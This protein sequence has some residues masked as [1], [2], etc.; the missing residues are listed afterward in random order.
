M[1]DCAWDNGFYLHTFIIAGLP[2]RWSQYKVT[3]A[4]TNTICS[5]ICWHQISWKNRFLAL[6]YVNFNLRLFGEVPIHAPF[7]GFSEICP[8]VESNINKIP[9]GASTDHSGSNGILVISISSVCNSWETA[10][11]KG[12]AKEIMTK[13]KRKDD[14]E[15]DLDTTVC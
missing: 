8:L 9:K 4:P 3:W 10:W 11:G 6:K 1:S 5:L 13:K 15:N 7:G 14:D 12:V 2:T